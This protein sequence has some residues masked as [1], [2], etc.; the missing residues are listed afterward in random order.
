MFLI[1]GM[2]LIIIT[3]SLTVLITMTIL[4]KKCSFLNGFTK[5]DLEMM[6]VFNSKQCFFL[7]CIL[8]DYRT[9]M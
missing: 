9:F 6:N 8:K 1:V 3:A 2:F 4:A 7:L 5:V